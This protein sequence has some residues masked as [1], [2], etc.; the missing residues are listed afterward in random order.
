MLFLCVKIIRGVPS[1][2]FVLQAIFF[3]E[4]YHKQLKE[5]L[6]IGN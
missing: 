5:T 6:T 4:K 1:R 2:I 3:G